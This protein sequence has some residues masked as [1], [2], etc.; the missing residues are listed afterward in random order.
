MKK[1]AQDCNDALQQKHFDEY[2]KYTQKHT[3]IITT[4]PKQHASYRKT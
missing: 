1:T 4:I 3:Q 2:R